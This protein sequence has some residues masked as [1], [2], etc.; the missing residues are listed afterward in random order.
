MSKCSICQKESELTK[1]SDEASGALKRH[2]WP[3][4]I[5]ELKNVLERA[6]I[7]FPG[8]TITKNNVLEYSI[9]IFSRTR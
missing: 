9:N 6:C 3:G 5:R 7:L 1:F 4:N 2:L 8:K